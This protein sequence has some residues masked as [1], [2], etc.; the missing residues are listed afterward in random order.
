MRIGMGHA[1]APSWPLA[2]R[3]V[4][5]QCQRQR[6]GPPGA[7][8]LAF[9]RQ[10]HGVGMW[11]IPANSFEQCRL[12]CRCPVLVEQTQQLSSD[13]TQ[14]VA[15][16]GCHLQQFAGCGC[17]PGQRVAAAMRAGLALVLDQGLQVPQIFE[18]PDADQS[19]AG[20]GPIRRC[21]R[22]CERAAHRPRPTAY[23]ARGCAAPSSRSSRTAKGHE[24][25]PTG[26]RASWPPRHRA[27]G[28]GRSRRRAAR[29]SGVARQQRPGARSTRRPGARVDPTPGPRTRQQPAH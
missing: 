28:P 26:P 6:R 23:A 1:G 20:D 10:T 19:C 25:A 21:R 18:S 17:D 4:F 8:P 9:Q 22:R 16:K 29:A 27:A 14:A 3:D 11:H 13:A 24:G 5:G 2:P 15:A 12:Q 7:F